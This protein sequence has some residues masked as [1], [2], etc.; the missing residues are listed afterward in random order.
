M[1]N[2]R[3]FLAGLG[4]LASG[5]AAAVGTGAFTSV[6]A[7]R[8]LEVQ[9]ADD[10]SAL[11]GIDDIDGSPNSA[12]VDVNGNSVSIDISSTNG[13]V[14]LNDNA[15]TKIL[16]LLKI[17]NQGTQ[18]VYVWASGMPSGVKLAVQPSSQIQNDGTGTGENQGAL[19]LNSNLSAADLDD[20]DVN[21]G[22]SG[23]GEEAAPELAPGDFINVELFASG[24]L[25]D[26]LDFDGT[27]TIHA[28]DVDQ[29]D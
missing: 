2:R 18:N 10:N 25:N 6:S 29:V 17:T 3:K 22:E 1:A 9:V 7:N 28:E 26:S 13:G 15:T 11:L 5:S 24:D 19:S 12:Y 20:D 21:V 16:D 23:G 8:D 14:G 4:A 27:I